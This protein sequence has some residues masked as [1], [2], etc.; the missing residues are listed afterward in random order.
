M[1]GRSNGKLP[2]ESPPFSSFVLALLKV[3][4][5]MSMFARTAIRRAVPAARTT[6]ARQFSGHGSPEEMHGEWRNLFGGLAGTF[7]SRRSGAVGMP[8]GT[9]EGGG[10]GA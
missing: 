8:G 3:A 9:F 6:P 7:R 1:R 10:A 2:D 4:T 5:E